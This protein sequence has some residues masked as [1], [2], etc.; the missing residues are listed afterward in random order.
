MKSI[1]LKLFKKVKIS[2]NVTDPVVIDQHGQ[3]QLH[4]AACEG[5]R[6][7][8]FLLAT[9]KFAVNQGDYQGRTALHIAAAM[10]NW[11]NV[12]LLVKKKAYI[13]ARTFGDC[14]TPAHHAAKHNAT[15]SLLCLCHCGANI[16]FRD[17]RLRT[18][19]FLAVEYGY[20]KSARLLLNYGADITSLDN[21]GQSILSLMM[22]NMPILAEEGLNKLYVYHPETQKLHFHLRPLEPIYN[23]TLKAQYSRRPMQFMVFYKLLNL[24]RHP[25]IQKFVDIKWNI[26]GYLEALTLL[27]VNSV[28]IISWSSFLFLLSKDESHIT[29]LKLE[30][31]FFLFG[32]FC[33]LEL[34]Y[35]ICLELYEYIENRRI[36]R[37]WLKQQ[38][39]SLN[40][41]L[42]YCSPVWPQKKLS[43][44]RTEQ[45]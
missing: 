30:I 2:E 5:T 22:V 34:V 28:F 45:R 14:Q 1:A 7:L 16:Q 39:E 41:D 19:L 32:L 24:V 31:W 3:N 44:N 20:E 36:F 43:K 25:V 33:I 29:E 40:N 37:L 23:N 10:D 27:V 35:A 38:Q 26:Y 11:K 8:S 13:N 4:K 17:H 12:E 6:E 42:L 21:S 18:P 9:K 15:R